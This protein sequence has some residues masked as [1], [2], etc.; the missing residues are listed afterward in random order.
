L[1]KHQRVVWIDHH[2]A[3]VFGVDDA[4]FDE[5]KVRA[6]ARHVARHAKPA[7]HEHE[8]PEDMHRFLR[9]VASTLDG[10]GQVLI[11]GPSTAKLE[12]LR[13]LGKEA[14][15]TEAKV[16]GIETVDHPSDGQLVAYAKRYFKTPH[17]S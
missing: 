6:P 11:V 7:T 5:A 1:E 16:V 17:P 10:A 4:L 8:H 2:E 15:A 13:H 9:E 12:L 14:R 3:R